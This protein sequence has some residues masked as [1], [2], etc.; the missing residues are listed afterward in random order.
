MSKHQRSSYVIPFPSVSPGL[1]FL[2]VS[3]IIIKQVLYIKKKKKKLFIYLW[4]PLVL[5]KIFKLFALF[6]TKKLFFTNSE[7]RAETQNN[8][9]VIIFSWNLILV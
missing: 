5:P 4:P 6:R 3:K 7:T 1:G 9:F 8:D 2:V